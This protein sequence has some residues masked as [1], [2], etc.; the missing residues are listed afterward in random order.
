MSQR[1]DE[2][3]EGVRCAVCERRFEPR[4]DIVFL[5]MTSER[6]HRECPEESP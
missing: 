4:D 5:P 6:F 3:Y 2:V 1:S